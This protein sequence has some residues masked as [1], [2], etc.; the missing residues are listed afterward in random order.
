MWYMCI[1]TLQTSN[2][3]E[4]CLKLQVQ[5]DHKDSQLTSLLSSSCFGF[6]ARDA[7]TADV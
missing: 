4:M 7:P 1:N 5:T 6:V 3:K 2:I